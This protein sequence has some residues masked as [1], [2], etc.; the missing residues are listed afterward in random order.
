MISGRAQII[1]DVGSDP[2]YKEG[3]NKVSSLMCAPLK[4]NDRVLGVI[5]ISSEEPYQYSSMDL[6]LFSALALQTAVSIENAIFFENLRETFITTI[7]TLAETVEKR[8]RYTGG[9]IRS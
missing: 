4:I 1:N 7:Q 9:H 6:K 2:R 3:K 5:N 8:D